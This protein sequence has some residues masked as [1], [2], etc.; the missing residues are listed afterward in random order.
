MMAIGLIGG[1]VSGI[2]S[3]MGAMGAKRAAE[4]NAKVSRANAKM[5]RSEGEIE[6]H[7]KRREMRRALGTLRAAYGSSGVEFAG[8][9]GLDLLKDTAVEYAWD[10]QKIRYRSEVSAVSEE[11][12]AELYEMEADS[13]MTSGIFGAATSLLK[14]FGTSYA[15]SSYGA[16]LA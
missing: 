14:G 13:A 9:S 3:V 2:G 1:L 16:D 12:Q 15:N 10:E 5:A 7:D 11:N 6:A 8:G 4:Y